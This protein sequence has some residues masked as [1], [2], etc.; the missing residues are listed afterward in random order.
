[1][2]AQHLVERKAA[3]GQ[4]TLRAIGE[5]RGADHRGAAGLQPVALLV[6]GP[7]RLQRFQRGR[8]LGADNERIL[9]GAGDGLVQRIGQLGDVLLDL[10]RGRVR[11]HP[12]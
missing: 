1:M 11:R 5:C 12:G 7:G 3:G 4:P 9:G 6:A 8:R 10:I 2:P